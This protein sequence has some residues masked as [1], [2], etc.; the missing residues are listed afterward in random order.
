MRL[1]GALP[2]NMQP[3]DNVAPTD[4]VDVVRALCSIL[5]NPVGFFGGRQ[6]WQCRTFR[7]FVDQDISLIDL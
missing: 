1:M 7:Q 5:L 6:L 3:H 4:M 2:S